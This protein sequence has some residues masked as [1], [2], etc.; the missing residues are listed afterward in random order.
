MPNSLSLLSSEIDTVWSSIALPFLAGSQSE[1]LFWPLDQPWL[2]QLFRYL[3]WFCKFDFLVPWRPGR[4]YLFL[5]LVGARASSCSSEHFSSRNIGFRVQLPGLAPQCSLYCYRAHLHAEWTCQTGA[6]PWNSMSIQ[7]HARQ[8]PN[9]LIALDDTNN[10]QPLRP[11]HHAKPPNGNARG[12]SVSLH[13]VA[14]WLPT[15]G[16]LSRAQTTTAPHALVLDS[17]HSLTKLASAPKLPNC[18]L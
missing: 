15:H 11:L 5:A 7:Q 18:R 16:T 14:K 13:V 9:Q 12:T 6:A 3:R 8:P 1:A 2:F 4:Q 17:T 10:L